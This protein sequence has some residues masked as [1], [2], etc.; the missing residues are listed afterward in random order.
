VVRGFRAHLALIA[1][2]DHDNVPMARAFS[3]VGWPQTETR[4]DLVPEV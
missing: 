1:D 3:D 4:I 2:T